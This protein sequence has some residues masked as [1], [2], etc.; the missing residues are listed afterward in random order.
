[1]SVIEGKW[2]VLILK[3][4]SFVEEAI[5]RWIGGLMAERVLRSSTT[6]GSGLH[7]LKRSHWATTLAVHSSGPKGNPDHERNCRLP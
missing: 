5:A 4:S 1:M 3:S 6:P 7:C 2:D